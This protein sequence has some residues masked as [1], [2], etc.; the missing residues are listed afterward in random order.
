VLVI[1]SSIL[2][3]RFSSFGGQYVDRYRGW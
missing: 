2:L 1:F 3:P